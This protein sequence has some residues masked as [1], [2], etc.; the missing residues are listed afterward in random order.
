M[1][2]VASPEIVFGI[3]FLP[4]S[5]FAPPFLMA[6]EQRMVL[7]SM[8]LGDPGWLCHKEEPLVN[9]NE[10]NICLSKMTNVQEFKPLEFNF[11]ILLF[12]LQV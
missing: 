1:A 4:D 11:D 5:N 10:I 3:D 9:L 8:C 6:T 12:H 2:Q 7:V